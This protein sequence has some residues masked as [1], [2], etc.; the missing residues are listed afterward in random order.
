MIVAQ[1]F[2]EDLIAGQCALHLRDRD[3]Q[4]ASRPAQPAHLPG[5]GGLKRFNL[6]S[7]LLEFSHPLLAALC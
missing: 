2:D 3:A 6:S 7:S 5:Q 4:G 1:Q